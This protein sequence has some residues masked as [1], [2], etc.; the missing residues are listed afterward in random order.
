MIKIKRM[1]VTNDPSEWK[2]VSLNGVHPYLLFKYS[3]GLSPW[4]HTSFSKQVLLPVWDKETKEWI[5][6]LSWDEEQEELLLRVETYTNMYYQ[7]VRYCDTNYH[8]HL[9][10]WFSKIKQDIINKIKKY[11]FLTIRVKF[12]KYNQQNSIGFFIINP[13]GI[14]LKKWKWEIKAHICLFHTTI[15]IEWHWHRCGF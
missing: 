3:L 4:G 13:K 6:I 7:I 15:D 11:L 5:T 1:M 14:G 2:G 9:Y 8:F 12:C 10:L